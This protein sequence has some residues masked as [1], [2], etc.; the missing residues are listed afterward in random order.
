MSLDVDAHSELM[1]AYPWGSTTPSATDETP[2][3]GA[4]AD[5]SLVFTD[6]G[7]P[8]GQAQA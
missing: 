2:D 8:P 6:T 1:P 4:Y 3:S 7:T 5:G